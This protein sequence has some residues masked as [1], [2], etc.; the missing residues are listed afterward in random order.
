MSIAKKI[1]KRES[2][3][4]R[5]TLPLT[6]SQFDRYKRL[7]FALD[8]RKETKLHDLHRERLDNLLDEVEAYLQKSS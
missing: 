1:E 7:A 3:I 4:E 6:P 5:M 8:Q 2:L